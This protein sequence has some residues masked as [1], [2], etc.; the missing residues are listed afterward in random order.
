MDSNRR[1]PAPSSFERSATV[2][3][4]VPEYHTAEATPKG[5]DPCC[6]SAPNTLPTTGLNRTTG[7]L[8]ARSGGL[9]EGGSRLH[10]GSPR[11]LDRRVHGSGVGEGE[12]SP[13][14]RSCPSSLP[15]D[16]RDPDGGQVGSPQPQRYLSPVR[17]RCRAYRIAQYFAA[18]RPDGYALRDSRCVLAPLL[19]KRKFGKITAWP[20]SRPTARYTDQRD[21]PNAGRTGRSLSPRRGCVA[22]SV[23]ASR[24][25]VRT[26]RRVHWVDKRSQGHPAFSL[27][28]SCRPETTSQPAGAT[29]LS[30]NGV[31]TSSRYVSS[32]PIRSTMGSLT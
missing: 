25:V 7:S 6:Q 20:R 14:A 16:A 13:A 32:R 26:P 3:D 30:V 15:S 9:A 31:A 21:R 29:D 18:G 10:R 11:C 4:V 27:A 17:A 28:T 2:D 22:G 23:R 19:F 24:R 5:N 12:R 1:R 8:R